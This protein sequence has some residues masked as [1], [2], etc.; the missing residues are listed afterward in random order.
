MNDFLQQLC[1]KHNVDCS[2][3]RT[4]ARLLDKARSCSAR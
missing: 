2:P 1:V 3:P 4:T